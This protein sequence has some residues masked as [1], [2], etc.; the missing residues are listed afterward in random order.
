MELRC[1]V[2]RIGRHLVVTTVGEIDLATVPLFRDALLRAISDE[3]GT[4]CYVDL[5]G[6]T[7][8]DDSGLGILLGVAARARE[9][10]GTLVVVCAGEALRSRLAATGLDRAIDVVSS[11]VG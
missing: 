9:H 3:P 1:R 6:V 8:L 5:D 4:T 2:R 7:S 10:G 11:V